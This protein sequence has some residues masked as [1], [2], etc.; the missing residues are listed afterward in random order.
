[1]G[2]LAK[3]SGCDLLLSTTML[4]VIQHDLSEPFTNIKKSNLKC[5]FLTNNK[6]LVRLADV[7]EKDAGGCIIWWVGKKEICLVCQCKQLLNKYAI[8]MALS[9]NQVM[10]KNYWRE[11]MVRRPTYNFRS[12]TWGLSSLL[13]PGRINSQIKFI[14]WMG[15]WYLG[16]GTSERL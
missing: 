15:A 4:L 5:P 13:K 1:M 8:N 3:T 10:I 6:H 9:C 12:S 11:N 7:V 14:T 2:S 16:H